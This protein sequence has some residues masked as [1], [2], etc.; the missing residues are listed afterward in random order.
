MIKFLIRV[1]LDLASR[2]Q[3]WTLMVLAL[4][5][6]GIHFSSNGSQHLMDIGEILSELIKILVG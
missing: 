1:F 6:L 2:P 5:S 3:F 4:T